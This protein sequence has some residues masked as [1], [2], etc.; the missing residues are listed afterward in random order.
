MEEPSDIRGDGEMWRFPL[1]RQRLIILKSLLENPFNGIYLCCFIS[2]TIWEIVI[3]NTTSQAPAQNIVIRS[4]HIRFQLKEVETFWQL[5]KD[6]GI[7]LDM[8]LSIRGIVSD[9]FEQTLQVSFAFR[10]FLKFHD[11]RRRCWSCWECRALSDAMNVEKSRLNS[12]N[13]RFF[14]V[15]DINNVRRFLCWDW[16][17]CSSSDFSLP[18]QSW[19]W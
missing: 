13:G 7:M 8:S 11:P 10:T 1:N 4:I 15:I 17:S 14:D 16:N 3:R 18:T 12:S 19:A 5:I 9:T 6:L 2:I